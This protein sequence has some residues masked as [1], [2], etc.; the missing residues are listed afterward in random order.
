M[1][2][3]III[4]DEFSNRDVLKMLLDK[5]CK[6]V[7]ILT[8]A[9]SLPTGLAALKKY[10]QELDL[11][12][13]DIEMPSGSGFELLEQSGDIDFH[14]IF[15]TAYD[16]YAIKAFKYA[17]LDYLLKPIDPAELVKAVDKVEQRIREKYPDQTFINLK[18]LAYLNHKLNRIALPTANGLKFVGV[19][20]LIRCEAEGSYTKVHLNDGTDLLV[21]KVL[22]DFEELLAELSF[23]RIHNS[24]LVNLAHVKEYVRNSGGSVIMS[25]GSEI[26]ISKRRKDAF[27]KKLNS[28]RI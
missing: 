19:D 15:T 9:D 3:A 24:D 17:A 28:M 21:S 10:R 8:M 27:L 23:F 20:E 2:K 1:I 25:D 4:D 14:I 11:I 22:K 13:L 26:M 5:H 18:E 6:N 16:Q 7:D 12:F